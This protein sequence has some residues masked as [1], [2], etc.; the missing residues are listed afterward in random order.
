MMDDRFG[1]ILHAK[2]LTF[3]CQ[4]LVGIVLSS[5]AR[6]D[7]TDRYVHLGS[8][9]DPRSQIQTQFLF[10]VFEVCDPRSVTKNQETSF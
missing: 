7:R 5:R 6:T 2:N 1:L 4:Q 3:D 10:R 8:I 9:P